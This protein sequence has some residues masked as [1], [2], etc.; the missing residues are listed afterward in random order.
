MLILI[1][2]IINNKD[3][4]QIL[5]ECKQQIPNLRMPVESYKNLIG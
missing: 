4:V 2:I 3:T 5:A 1:L